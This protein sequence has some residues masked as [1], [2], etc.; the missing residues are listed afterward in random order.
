MNARK[1]LNAANLN[2]ILLIA[3][4]AGWATESW[5]IF[6]LAAVALGLTSWHAE[7]IRPNAKS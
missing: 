4:V 7:Q 5:E 6:L 3:G 1:K 2:G